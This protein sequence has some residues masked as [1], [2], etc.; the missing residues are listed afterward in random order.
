MNVNTEQ[1]K[2]IVEAHNNIDEMVCVNY[3]EE[4]K[5]WTVG[6]TV[7]KCDFILASVRRPVRVFKTLDT[8]V[9]FLTDEICINEF[10]VIR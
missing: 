5:G 4:L 9:S 3:S 10:K 8:I 7:G 1:F 6:I 2:S